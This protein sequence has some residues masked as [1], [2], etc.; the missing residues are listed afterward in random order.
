[1]YGH[2]EEMMNAVAQGLSRGGTALDIFDAARTHVSYILPSLW[3]RRGVMIG[4]PTYEVKLFPPV[5]EVL[6]MAVHKRIVRRKAAYFGSYGWSGGA[7]KE[8]KKIIEPAHWELG[9]SVEFIGSPTR[10]ELR[11]GE[12]LGRTFAEEIA[13]LPES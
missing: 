13:A 10:E 8:V 5:A 9:R 1:M 12:A 3:L 2:T 7:L 4:A 6:N 11:K